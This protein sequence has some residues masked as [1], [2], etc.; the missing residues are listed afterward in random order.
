M[1]GHG[2]HEYFDLHFYERRAIILDNGDNGTRHSAMET[3][4]SA[5]QVPPV[6]SI[7]ILKNYEGEIDSYEVINT[8]WSPPTYGSMAWPYG[9]NP[10]T[11]IWVD[12]LVTRSV[13]IHHWESPLTQAER[14]EE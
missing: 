12:V 3:E 11:G 8:Q 2:H 1:K 13:G 7:I 5:P 9:K 4:F 6:G 10:Q 14:D